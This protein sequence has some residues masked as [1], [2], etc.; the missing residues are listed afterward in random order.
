MS[1]K[2]YVGN[3]SYNASDEDLETL[4][5]EVC[6]VVSVRVIKDYHTG[7][8][9]GFAFVEVGEN[10]DPDNIINSLD[11][12]ELQGRPIRVSVARENNEGGGG[13][14]RFGNGGGGGGGGFKKKRWD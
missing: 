1:K 9:K 13:G 6:E 3:L 14:R 8:S 4:F 5:K 11:N 7:R 12:K 2:L 10:A